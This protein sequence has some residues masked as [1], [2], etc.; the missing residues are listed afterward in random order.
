M[1]KTGAEASY[2]S[3]M[4]KTGAE[5]SNNEATKKDA[6]KVLSEGTNKDPKKDTEENGAETED[7]AQEATSKLKEEAF[8]KV[9]LEA[10]AN[11]GRKRNGETPKNIK[12]KSRKFEGEKLQDDPEAAKDAGIETDEY[13]L[14]ILN[15]EKLED[16]N[17]SDKPKALKIWDPGPESV[18][19]CASLNLNLCQSQSQLEP[20]IKRT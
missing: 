20:L 16:F 18:L 11:K 7:E 12:A 4:N 5:A 10:D 2:N 15:F 14:P 19:T 1:N 8:A 17:E 3:A 9:P 6:E 13:G